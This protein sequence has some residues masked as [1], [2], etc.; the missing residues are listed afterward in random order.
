VQKLGAPDQPECTIGAI[1]AGGITAFDDAAIAAH[2]VTARV[3]YALVKRERA[4]LLRRECV[5]RM[6]R[7]PVNVRGQVVILVDDGVATGATMRAAVAALR[8]QSAA[9]IVVAVPVGSRPVCDALS[10]VADQVICP[11]TPEPFSAIEPWYADF[12]ETSEE[13]VRQYLSQPTADT[14]ERSA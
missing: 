10:E 13:D 6:N 12:S 8:R 5:Y 3:L 14:A 7:P 4:E 9:G 1:A 11:L 2:H